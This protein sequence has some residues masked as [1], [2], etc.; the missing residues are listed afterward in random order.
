MDISTFIAAMGIPS[1]IC[2]LLV[3]WLKKKIEERDARID[4]RERNLEKLMLMIM[5]TSRANNVLAMATARAVQRIPDAKCNGDMTAALE[6]ATKL[7]VAEK[8][9]LVEQGVK[10]IFGE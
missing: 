1:A 8:D 2:G 6:E 7:Q 9:F 5:Q 3:W 10:H 4:E